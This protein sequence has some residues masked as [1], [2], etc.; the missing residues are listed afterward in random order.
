MLLRLLYFDPRENHI[1]LNL[2]LQIYFINNI[3]EKNIIRVRL[4]K[5]DEYTCLYTRERNVLQE[6]SFFRKKEKNE[7]S[8]I[9]DK[10]SQVDVGTKVHPCIWRLISH[11]SQ[12]RANLRLPGAN[13]CRAPRLFFF[14][15]HKEDTSRRGK[16]A[17][18]FHFVFFLRTIPP[19]CFFRRDAGK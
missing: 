14:P 18:T 6:R 17:V 2:A 13:F 12:Q 16:F 4:K 1:F 19:S 15:R 5:N 9:C 11:A 10:K 7:L 3:Y 8:I